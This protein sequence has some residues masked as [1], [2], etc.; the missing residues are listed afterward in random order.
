MLFKNRYVDFVVEENLPYG[1]S[2]EHLATTPWLYVKIEKRNMNTMDLVKAVMKN[3]WLPRKKV[4]IAGLKDKHALARQWLC[5]HSSDVAKIGDKKFLQVIQQI[6]KVVDFGFAKDPLNLSS[7]ITNTFWIRLRKDPKNREKKALIASFNDPKS[8][9]KGYVEPS[10]LKW[11]DVK[12]E[13]LETRLKKL[14]TEWFLNLYGEQRF[15][16]T[17]ANH[18]IAQEIIAGTKK[19]L[20]KSEIIFKLQSLSSRLFNNYCTYRETKYGRKM[21]E[22]DIMTGV[23]KDE[24][25]VEATSV[26]GPIFWYDLKLADPATEAG[27]L[28]KEWMDHF[29][30]NKELFEVYEKHGI[31]WLRR[32]IRVK[33][34]KASH[35]RQWDDLLLQFTLPKGSYASVLVEELLGE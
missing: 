21:L 18:R 13:V 15:G 9:T 10:G 7:Q 33:P 28:E 34:M 11:A 4:G 17:H 30:I 35:S 31:F 14:Y 19:W 27:K 25:T 6:T 16:F 3:T 5:F 8:K 12:N 1:L 26:T 32:P 20:D 22:G 29:E 2:K 24:T 23:V